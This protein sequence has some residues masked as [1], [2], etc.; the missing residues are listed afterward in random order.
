MTRRDLAEG[1]SD[2]RAS[3][4]TMIGVPITGVLARS[5]N[6]LAM[7]SAAV[8][9]FVVGGT[10][11]GLR[12][13][14]MRRDVTTI[15]LSKLLSHP[16][17]VGL[18][19]WLL[20]PDDPTL[21][22]RLV[23]AGADSRVGRI[24]ACQGKNMK[25]LNAKYL[26]RPKSGMI[27]KEERLLARSHYYFR[28]AHSMV[29]GKRQTRDQIVGGAWW[30]DAD[31]FNTIRQRSKDSGTHLS[32]MARYSC[33]IARRW[34]GKVDIVVKALLAAPLTAYIGIGTIQD[35]YQ[36]FQDEPDDD[37]STWIPAT[38]IAQ[39]FIPGLQQRNPQTGNRVY[40]DAFQHVEQTRIGWDPF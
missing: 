26:A 36:P 40:A 13:K 20:P 11:V 4:A 27:V 1:K 5:N 38:D 2:V 37:L 14:G 10:L 29:A 33:A 30:L 21:R 19:M 25:S 35:F 28:F 9:L 22:A 32:S 3:S 17:A 18:T 31:A 12:T 24:A 8:S 16:L 6:M 23:V 7:S 15:A 39:I 34:T